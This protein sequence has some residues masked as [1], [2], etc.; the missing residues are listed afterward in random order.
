M[1]NRKLI[2]GVIALIFIATPLIWWLASPLFIDEAVDEA[3]PFDLPVVAEVAEMSPS[4]AEQVME[5]TMKMVDEEFVDDLSAEQAAELEE[6]VVAAAEKMPDHPMDEEMPTPEAE[7]EWVLIE[8]GQFRDADSAHRGSG[9]FGIY[10]QG[11][12]RLMRFENFEVTNGPDLHVFLVENIDGDSMG[13]SV[14]LGSLKG[15]VGNQNYEIPADVDLDQF[16][17]VMIYCVPFHVVFSTA[18]FE[19]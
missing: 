17:G 1:K 7:I 5:D 6:I 10:E 4:E 19:M 12:Q 16:K 9:D 14:D 11:D 8:Q 2:I 3:F 15:N 13:A 18:P